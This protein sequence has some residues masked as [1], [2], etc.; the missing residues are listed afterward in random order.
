[1]SEGGLGA[2][3]MNGLDSILLGGIPRTN[4][5]PI[6]QPYS[7]GLVDESGCVELSPR[8]RADLLDFDAWGEILTTYGRTMRVA[9]A[10]TDSHGHQLGKCHNAQPA[11]KLVRDAAPDRGAGC[12][13]CITTHLPCTAVA[14]AL[15]TGG[16]VMVRD[17]A[18][19]THVAVPLLLGKQHL[20]AIIAGQVFDRYPEPL[21]LRRVAK[22]FGVSAQ[23]LWDVARKQRPVSS[24]ILQESGDL[25]CTLGHAF[26]RQRYGAML[27][28][29][30]AET[31]GRFRSLV[32]GVRDYALF[33]MDPTGRVTSWNGGAERM[34]GYAEAEIV[35]QNFSCIFTPEDIQNGSPEKQ[36]HKALQAGRTEDEGWRVRGNGNQ[37]WANVN[38]TAL[39]EDAGPARGFTIIMQDATE[40]RKIAMVL[41]EALQ[42]RAHLQEK[43]LS[44]VSHELRTPLTAIHFFTTNVLDGLLGDLTPAQR[45]H[46]AFALDNVKQLKDMV[47]DLLDITRVET[48]KLTIE[49]EHASPV[50]LIAKALAT[51]RTNAAEK[52]ITLRSEVAPDLPFVWADP[53]RVRQIL[54]NLID[55]AIKFTPESG[56]VSVESQ[57]FTEDD[58]FLCLAVSDTGCGISPE[59]SE[60]VFD[61]L[62][63]IKSST[64]PSRSGLGLGLFI[65][66]ELVSGHGG[67]IW[68]QSQVGHGSTFYFTLPVFS[69]AKMC[70]H[71][72]TAPNLEAGS[73]TLIAVDLIAVE[74]AVQAD[75]L[76]EIRRILERCIRAGRDVLLPSMSDAEPVETFF[77]V[78]CTGSSGFA[79]IASR[80]DTELRNFDRASQLK[81]VI[82]STTLLVPADQSGEEQ[83][84]EVAARIEG[85]VQ[86][87]LLGKER[88]K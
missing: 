86:A 29:K 35:G 48:R 19:L 59:N 58:D 2:T 44:H 49:P 85:L 31:N 40:R 16:A 21:S 12:P 80:I 75:L 71:V 38:I 15:Q 20:G 84:S 81:P 74:T 9:V 4:A 3:G 14:K 30:L 65:S 52:N 64:E 47:S 5:V 42:E 73:V 87:H 27:E 79:V 67:R 82:S 1:M 45:E 61:R 23:Q 60:R 26:L 66:R 56:T 62:A 28:A 55:N 54:V 72:F 50:K 33:T 39:L 83:I 70:A 41:E 17:Q 22:Q 57:P 25:L 6:H 34:L 76:P 10:L 88:L 69:L 43:F 7:S 53:A 46:L 68:L 37:F 11:W 32:E 36:L 78:A 24:A 51:C 63:Q 77:I 8:L 18:G 13:F